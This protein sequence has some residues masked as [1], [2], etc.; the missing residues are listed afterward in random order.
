MLAGVR[1][2]AM[3]V[4]RCPKS[5]ERKLNF[6]RVEGMQMHRPVAVIFMALVS[7]VVETV[8]GFSED[9]SVAAP[10]GPIKAIVESSPL[11]SGESLQLRFLDPGLSVRTL[12][13]DAD[14]QAAVGKF[15]AGDWVIA[16]V[17]DAK[18]P[19]KLKTVEISR[20][21]W[22]LPAATGLI[23]G[24]MA[25][26]I[27]L[28][29]LLMRASLLKL[30][31]GEDGRYSKSKTQMAFW[32]LAVFSV[33]LGTVIARLVGS[34]GDLI[35]GVNIPMH[36]LVLTGLSA[37]TFG[38]AKAITTPKV[39]QAQADAANNAGPAQDAAA[40]DPNANAVPPLP[41]LLA[42]PPAAPVPPAAVVP[43]EADAKKNADLK[44]KAKP[45]G[46]A[47]FSDLFQNDAETFDLG[48]TQMVLITLLVI[49]LFLVSGVS[50]LHD[51]ALQ[52]TVT[53]PDV[54]TTLLSA[55]GLGQGA[56][57]FKKAAGN[58]GES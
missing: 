47:R 26:L 44:V 39:Q 52:A 45:V 6:D 16:T 57:L 55:F 9:T 49:M 58:P 7:L 21:S 19:Q 31:E 3:P 10:T 11:E 37:F 25:G 40:A 15:V 13:V 46:G 29:W 20:V 8:A 41:A 24:S 18:N 36:L 4:Y 35:G 50:F 1:R 51:V 56:Y 17:Y 34:Q 43:S 42:V 30:L 54:D 5:V 28:T 33:Y 32:F 27:L 23:L 53:L 14:A 38:A 2:P 48:D 22:S 12:A